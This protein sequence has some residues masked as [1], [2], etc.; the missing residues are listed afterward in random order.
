[1]LKSSEK[2]IINDKETIHAV[3]ELN[4][5]VITIFLIIKHAA[6]CD[7]AYKICVECIFYNF[8]DLLIL[9]Y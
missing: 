8:L 5:D 9:Y 6:L 4:P 7:P 2:G 3:H 1:M